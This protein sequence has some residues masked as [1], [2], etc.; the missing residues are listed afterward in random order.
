MKTL[1]RCIFAF[2]FRAIN[3]DWSLSCYEDKPS[4]YEAN[5]CL[6]V[7]TSA[8]GD[9]TPLW[10]RAEGD[11]CTA[12]LSRP[13]DPQSSSFPEKHGLFSGWRIFCSSWSLVVTSSITTAF[14]LGSPASSHLPE[15]MSQTGY[16]ELSTKYFWFSSRLLKH[17]SR[18][19]VSS[20][21]L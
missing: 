13:C 3:V 9:D 2:R 14:F 8:V 20:K 5:C 7:F 11:F 6:C 15:N 10:A 18:W 1:W 21:L 4:G 17:A 12:S 16:S 19:T